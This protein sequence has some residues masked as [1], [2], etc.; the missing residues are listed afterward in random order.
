MQ[1]TLLISEQLSSHK[2]KKTGKIPNLKTMSPL[3]FL[4]A[5]LARSG[6][7]AGPLLGEEK[8]PFRLW[9]L[10]AFTNLTNSK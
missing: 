10:T 5:Y 4:S 8:E 6:W 7:L 3:F 9:L 2:I 1:E